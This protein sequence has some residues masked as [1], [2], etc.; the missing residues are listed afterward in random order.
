MTTLSI[1]ISPEQEQFIQSYIKEGKA[2]NKAQVVRRALAKF[3]EDEA[4][5]AVLQAQREVNEGRLL[6]GD[7]R[8]LLDL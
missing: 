6:K 4:V 1:P 7:L 5:E 2:D 3:A 8:K